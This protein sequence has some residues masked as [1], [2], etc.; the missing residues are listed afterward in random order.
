[1]KRA[2]RVDLQKDFGN[3]GATEYSETELLS[4]CLGFK[5]RRVRCRDLKPPLALSTL[6]YWPHHF[7]L[8]VI[9]ETWQKNKPTKNRMLSG[10]GIQICYSACSLR[11]FKASQ[12]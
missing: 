11:R 4:Y 10:G 7:L 1:M 5:A 12:A 8:D 3:G 2:M 9:A 6:C